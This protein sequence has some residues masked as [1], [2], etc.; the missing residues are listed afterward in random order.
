MKSNE[1][2]EQRKSRKNKEKAELLTLG[3]VL[4]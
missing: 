2:R 4:F 1:P 3:Q